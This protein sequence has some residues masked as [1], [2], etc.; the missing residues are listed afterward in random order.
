MDIP[1][2]R[3]EA[4]IEIYLQIMKRARDCV[5]GLL[6]HC[7]GLTT[8]SISFSSFFSDVPRAHA[9]TSLPERETELCLQRAMS[10]TSTRLVGDAAL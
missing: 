4:S 7:S 3:S 9:T 8:T 2:T 5:I 10:L 6:F 1:E